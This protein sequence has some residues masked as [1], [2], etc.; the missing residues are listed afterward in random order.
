MVA[1]ARS[2]AVMAGRD[3]VA[4]HDIARAAECALPHR[5]V[6]ATRERG[7]ATDVVDECLAQVDAPRR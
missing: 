7:A 5:L 4:P 6:L 3:H 2:F 1:L